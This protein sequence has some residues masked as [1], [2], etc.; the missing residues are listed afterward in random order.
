VFNRVNDPSGVP[1]QILGSITAPGEVL[2]I[3]RNGIIF[4]AGAQ[5]SVGALI[6]S[7][8]DIATSSF[9]SN[10][11]YGSPS[12]SGA[13]NGV[14]VAQG[15]SITT[16]APASATNAGGFV[17]L[18]G[19]SVE[20][21]GAITTPD[22]QTILAAGQSFI[23]RQG[24]GNN[25]G[26]GN[27]QTSTTLGTEAAVTGGGAAIN[28][29]LI[30]ATTGNITMVGQSVTQAGVAYSTTSVAQRGTIHLLTNATDPTTSVTLAPGSLTTIL[31]DTR[32]ATA[33]DAQRETLID[34]SA[35]LQEQE[36][37]A[38]SLLNDQVL[39]P[40]RLD[41][42]R[43]EITTDGTVDFGNNSLTMATGGQLAVS[44]A[45]RVFV[46]SGAL[47]DVAG[48]VNVV[49][50]ANANTLAVDVQG[51]QL[52]DSPDN[53]DSSLLDSLTVNVAVG[54]LV[55][56]PAGTDGYVQDRYY[57]AGGL[58]EVAVSSATSNTQS[59]NGPRRAVRS[60][61]PGRRWWR[62][63]AQRSISRAAR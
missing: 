55:L 36:A 9:V 48:S 57:A 11:I 8:A 52:R 59:S 26:T 32:G 29:G 21:D 60:R 56:V 22:G 23:V 44:A 37:A 13:S 31:P 40:D 19:S 15:A 12:L 33:S 41:Q 54:Q 18:L 25:A 58:L 51:F 3:N 5:V 30:Q 34:E 20:N 27:A 62:S 43:I 49:V 10:G 4:G 2:V 38:A 35:T 53:R 46:E 14:T 7:T 1:S 63:L 61:C 6:A 24:Y 16:N 50:P 39:L 42:S 28:T 45:Q 47:L 17:M